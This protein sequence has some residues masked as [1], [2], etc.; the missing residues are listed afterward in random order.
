MP[1][2]DQMSSS[3]AAALFLNKLSYLKI[4]VLIPRFGRGSS[5]RA[6][7]VLRKLRTFNDFADLQK[8]EFNA[9]HS[10]HDRPWGIKQPVAMDMLL[11]RK[12]I[13]LA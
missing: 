3:P 7:V 11:P 10:V 12:H 13:A 1:F 4:I 2:H 8:H 5:R 6:T 9:S